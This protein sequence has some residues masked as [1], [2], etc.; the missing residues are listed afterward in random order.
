MAV[1]LAGGIAFA[2]LMTLFLVPMLYLIFEDIGNG[3]RKSWRWI[4]G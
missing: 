3:L 4:K 2:T 1:S